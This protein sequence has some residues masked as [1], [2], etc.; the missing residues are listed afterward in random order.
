MRVV[1]AVGEEQR[2]DGD[3]GAAEQDDDGGGGDENLAATRHQRRAEPVRRIDRRAALRQLEVDGRA[4][5]LAEH[6]AVADLVA[7]R[8]AQ[9]AEVRHERDVAVAVLERHAAAEAGHLADEAHAPGGD[10]AHQL[11]RPAAQLD[12]A[13]HH[14][15][16]RASNPCATPQA[17][18]TGPATGRS[19]PPLPRCKPAGAGDVGERHLR[20][21]VER[22]R[23]RLLA[24]RLLDV[25]LARF[26]AHGGE[27]VEI[28][29]HDAPE[30]RRAAGPAPRRWRRRPRGAGSRRSTACRARAAAASPRSRR[31][32]A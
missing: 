23:Q 11:A 32:S 2:R 25:E 7:D 27:L 30:R 28:A 13:P 1:D 29:R 4:V 14:L 8:A 9:R 24:P 17:P 21:E 26:V 5:G 10:G 16:A 12:A 31:S 15:D 3:D 6:V 20:A 18:T 19:Q 22:V